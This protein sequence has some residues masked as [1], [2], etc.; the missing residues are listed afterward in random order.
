MFK[1]LGNSALCDQEFGGFGFN[2]TD[3]NQVRRKIF[4]LKYKK[5]SKIVDFVIVAPL[6]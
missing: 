5:D 6:F 4:Q 3:V 2:H 1:L